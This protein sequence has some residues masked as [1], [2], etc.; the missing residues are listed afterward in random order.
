VFLRYCP[1]FDFLLPVLTISMKRTRT[2]LCLDSGTSCRLIL[3]LGI[4]V[5]NANLSNDSNLLWVSH[6]LCDK[7]QSLSHMQTSNSKSLRRLTNL[8]CFY[9]RFRTYS[10]ILRLFNVQ[11]IYRISNVLLSC[12]S[13]TVL[14]E[15]KGKAKEKEE[16][17]NGDKQ[18][19]NKWKEN[20]YCLIQKIII[21]LLYI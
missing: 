13:I 18:K 19:S 17:V 6:T 10:Q 7:N 3:I 5:S 21:I 15:T 14:G 2:M 20:L 12:V 8:S 16:K 4:L 11:K 9:H 1:K